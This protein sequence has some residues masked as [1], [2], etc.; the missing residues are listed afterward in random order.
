MAVLP[1]NDDPYPLKHTFDNPLYPLGNGWVVHTE[2]RSLD[3]E[4]VEGRGSSRIGWVEN[5]DGIAWIGGDLPNYV[6][7]NF[8]KFIREHTQLIPWSD[9]FKGEN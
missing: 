6:Y 8:E 4:K 9:A 1:S 3:V 7:A 2:F 5:Y